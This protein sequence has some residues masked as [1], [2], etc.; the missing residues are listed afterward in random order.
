M[1]I[2]K[3]RTNEIRKREINVFEFNYCLYTWHHRSYTYA[4]EKRTTTTTKSNNQQKYRQSR[5]LCVK[6]I[7]SVCTWPTKNVC[8]HLL[9]SNMCA[10]LKTTKKN[11]T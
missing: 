5:F 7:Y 1:S 2:I 11:C 4:D 10:Y 9:Y 6:K 3:I 8:K